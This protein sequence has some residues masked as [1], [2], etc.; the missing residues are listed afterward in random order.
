MVLQAEF[1]LSLKMGVWVQRSHQGLHNPRFSG[2]PASNRG[3]EFNIYTSLDFFL[4]RVQAR[5]GFWARFGSFSLVL[6]GI[7]GFAD[8]TASFLFQRGIGSRR[9]T[10]VVSQG[11][12][13]L[14]HCSPSASFPLDQLPQRSISFI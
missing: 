1:R 6:G 11:F 4:G 10:A 14:V 2:F 8:F 12:L 5:E 13:D 7:T 3:C 9:F